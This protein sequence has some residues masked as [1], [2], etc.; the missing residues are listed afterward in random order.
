MNLLKCCCCKWYTMWMA[1]ILYQ[2]RCLAFHKDVSV[3]DFCISVKICVA[4]LR[5]TCEWEQAFW[6]KLL[7]LSENVNF[8]LQTHSSQLRILIYFYLGFLSLLQ[9]CWPIFFAGVH[10]YTELPVTL[11]DVTIWDTTK[12]GRVCMKLILV[13]TV[14]RMDRTVP[15]LTGLATSALQCLTRVKCRE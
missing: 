9:L 12:L 13:E 6:S 10:F 14:W 4:L 7:W 3:S 1:K 5:W 11:S 8:T 2:L 15:L